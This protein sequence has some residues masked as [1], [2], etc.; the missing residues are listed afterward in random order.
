VN[1]VKI[2]YILNLYKFA[3]YSFQRVTFVYLWRI[4][5]PKM[6]TLKDASIILNKNAEI[7]QFKSI[8]IIPLGAINKISFFRWI[9]YFEVKFIFSF[10]KMFFKN[11]NCFII[12]VYIWV[13]AWYFLVHVHNVQWLSAYPSPQTFT[14]SFGWEHSKL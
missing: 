13:T 10:Y 1:S 3:Q 12:I 5:L 9:K 4:L 2:F 8:I 7:I 14:S 11:F 6:T